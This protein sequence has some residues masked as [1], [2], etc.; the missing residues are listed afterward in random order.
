MNSVSA[1]RPRTVYHKMFFA[2]LC[3]SHSSFRLA[4][5]LTDT[6]N[7]Q[8]WSGKREP[9][10]CLCVCVSADENDD[11]PT[12]AS[13]LFIFVSEINVDIYFL[14]FRTAII[15]INTAIVSFCR[16]AKTFR[17]HFF[18]AAV[19][20]GSVVLILFDG[21]T[22]FDWLRRTKN[23]M[24]RRGEPPQQMEHTMQTTVRPCD[25]YLEQS[26]Q[27]FYYYYHLIGTSCLFAGNYDCC[28]RCSSMRSAAGC[29]M[30]I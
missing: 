11:V 4:G 27:D 13:Q 23:E 9:E 26:E 10:W 3:L 15:E 24:K 7:E 25:K 28:C 16:S 12:G 1:Q 30:C 17:V 2:F 19:A 21:G 18:P 14:L 20:V 8:K 22:P 5:L 29:N 6:P